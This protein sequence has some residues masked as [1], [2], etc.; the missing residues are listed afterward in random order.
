M[1][2]A[3]DGN[4]NERT[5]K[6]HLRGGPF[7]GKI[8][9]VPIGTSRISI[10][11]PDISPKKGTEVHYMY[12]PATPLELIDGVQVFVYGGDANVHLDYCE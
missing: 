4:A 7:D 5:T 12:S 11:A 6:I 1:F 9:R 3:A 8:E 2:P 10:R